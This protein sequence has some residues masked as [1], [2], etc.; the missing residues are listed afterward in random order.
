MRGFSAHRP[1]GGQRP[2]HSSHPSQNDT[3]MGGRDEAAA[4][5]IL[6]TRGSRAGPND[7]VNYYTYFDIESKDNTKAIFLISC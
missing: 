2:E 6:H 1:S 4:A 3:K 5:R 7:H